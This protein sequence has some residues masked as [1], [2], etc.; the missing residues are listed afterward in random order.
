MLPASLV[1]CEVPNERLGRFGNLDA[2]T[3]THLMPC[4]ASDDGNIATTK[5]HGRTVA[6]DDDLYLAAGD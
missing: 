6:V 5:L 4:L 3:S 1:R 2:G